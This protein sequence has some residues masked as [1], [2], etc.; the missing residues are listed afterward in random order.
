MTAP[1]LDAR[2]GD[3]KGYAAYNPTAPW[4]QGVVRDVLK[5]FE[6]LEADDAL[7]VGPRTAGYAL[8]ERVAPSGLRYV[9]V[10]G[11]DTEHR[12]GVV[13]FRA[14][15]DAI[16]RLRQAERLDWTWVSD[17]SAVSRP[18]SEDVTAEGFASRVL[19]D[20][21]HDLRV[22][23]PVVP[24]LHSESA[25]LT[26]FLRRV[27]DPYG[28]RV[29]SGR[30]SGGPD[31][32]RKVAIRAWNRYHE[33]DEDGEPRRQRTL[34]LGVG[35]LDQA[36]V[37]NV[38]RPHIE[39]VAA[40]LLGLAERHSKWNEE[41]RRL[42][43]EEVLRFERV[44]VTP[45][46]AL[47]LDLPDLDKPSLMRYGASG[48]GDWDRDLSL[49]TEKVEVEALGPQRLRV[50]VTTAIEDVLDMDVLEQARAEEKVQA[51]RVD[52]M[53]QTLGLGDS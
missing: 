44:A 19:A 2:A 53:R 47:G 12:D 17:G 26:A 25:E 23:Q 10:I 32:A 8:T 45:Q 24:E 34:I 46:Q 4:K 43:V 33:Q 14:V 27:T 42:W 41:T 36:G 52:A 48:F 11:K 3:P 28:V 38:M 15:E 51:E 30:G 39:H 49:L 35:D 31:L 29:E 13:S 16:K 6:E 5:L 50:A 18:V 20:Y 40:F 9:K 37:R 7:P 1:W 21:E 22:G